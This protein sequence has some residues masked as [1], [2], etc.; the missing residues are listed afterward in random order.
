MIQPGLRVPARYLVTDRSENEMRARK[1]PPPPLATLPPKMT[2]V[3]FESSAYT[4]IR[5]MRE[6][7]TKSRRNFKANAHCIAPILWERIRRYDFAHKYHMRHAYAMTAMA[8]TRIA[9]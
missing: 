6:L 8:T 3:G 7:K 9:S 2:S 4:P 1:C 5:A